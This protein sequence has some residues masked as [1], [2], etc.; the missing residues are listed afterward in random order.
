MSY[1]TSLFDHDAGYYEFLPNNW[2]PGRIAPGAKLTWSRKAVH[3]AIN[4][5]LKDS[6]VIS[7]TYP[8]SGLCRQRVPR[9]FLQ[10]LHSPQY[11]KANIAK[12]VLAVYEKETGPMKSAT[13][14]CNP[15][16][17]TDISLYIY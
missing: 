17:S 7:A 2:I 5:D 14:K 12:S 8:K 1:D 11:Q 6:D 9:G 3:A 13:L 10:T 16:T 15:V 4:V